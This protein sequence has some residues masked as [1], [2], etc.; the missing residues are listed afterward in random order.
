MT[1]GHLPYRRMSL[2]LIG[3][4]PNN[5]CAHKALWGGDAECV[6]ITAQISFLNLKTNERTIVGKFLNEKIKPVCAVYLLMSLNFSALPQT[7]ITEGELR[8]SLK[9]NDLNTYMHLQ[10]G[11]K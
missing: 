1:L 7:Y 9:E 11:I 3:G 4:L 5:H 10:G 6:Q 2:L 8:V